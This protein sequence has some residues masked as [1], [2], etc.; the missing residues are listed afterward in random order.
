MQ[1]I[2]QKMILVH[3]RQC[4]RVFEERLA[5]NYCSGTC[6]VA[7]FRG[8]P[9]LGQTEEE[10]EELRAEFFLDVPLGQK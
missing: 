7:H 1:R 10:K 9:V 8:E 2:G 6:R 4:G 5:K 3:C